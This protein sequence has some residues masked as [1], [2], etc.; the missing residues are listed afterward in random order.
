HELG[1]CMSMVLHNICV[2]AGEGEWEPEDD[3]E[4]EEDGP[5]AGLLALEVDEV[6]GDAWHCRLV[7]TYYQW[8]YG[9]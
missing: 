7:D 5:D 1:L 9:E 6:G 8:H 2:E 4:D 3:D